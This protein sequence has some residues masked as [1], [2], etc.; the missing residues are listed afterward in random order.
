ML[1]VSLLG[2][3]CRVWSHLGCL[4]WKVTIFAHSGA[5]MLSTVHK[6][7]EIQKLRW[8]WPHRNLPQRSVWA[9]ATPTLVSLRGWFE[10]FH[11]H[12]RHFYMGVSPFPGNYRGPTY[13]AFLEFIHCDFIYNYMESRTRGFIIIFLRYFFLH[14]SQQLQQCIV[15]SLTN[16]ADSLLPVTVFKHSELF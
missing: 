6:K 16:W 11:E 5:C 4:G 1:V 9:L 10:F 3:N 12:S 15:L 8:H 2:V 14:V 7:K 13:Q